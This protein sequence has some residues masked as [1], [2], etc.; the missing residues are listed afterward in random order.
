MFFFGLVLPII[1]RKKKDPVY[2]KSMTMHRK[3]NSLRHNESIRSVTSA[4]MMRAYSIL[5][6]FSIG[7]FVFG[8]GNIAYAEV[9]PAVLQAIL[10]QLAGD[11]ASTGSTAAVT[12]TGTAANAA[13]SA[14]TGTA[15]PAAG[16]NAGASTTAAPA[17]EAD[18]LEVI[19][20]K[21]GITGENISI[22]VQA[23]NKNNG[24]ASGY[25]GTVILKVEND[26]SATVPYV[27]GY[28]FNSTDL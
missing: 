3:P 26:A 4:T 18:R 19:L 16:T 5:A 1:S 8:M 14:T 12:S 7:T 17:N 2:S 15:A 27:S 6:V 9:D 20:G 28:T 13:G 23:K 22:T 25:R 21:T 10:G 24:I 11:T